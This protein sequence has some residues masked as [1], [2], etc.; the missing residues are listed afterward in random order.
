MMIEGLRRAK[1]A[2]PGKICRP[3]YRLLTS[4]AHMLGAKRRDLT[5]RIESRPPVIPG[6]VSQPRQTNGSA[7]FSLDQ[8]SR[9]AAPSTA[10]ASGL[11]GLDAVLALQGEPEQEER[12][13]RR[14]AARR[15][16]DLLDTLDSL[17]ISLLSGRVPIDQIGRLKQQMEAQGFPSGDPRLD[18]LIAHIELRA[19]VEL[20]K[21]A[22]AAAAPRD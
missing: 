20:A 3:V 14:Q 18:E 9:G 8:T 2:A 17:K 10:A 11:I 7:R 4:R 19:G 16:Y 15:G 6:A 1:P 22:A 21:I 5:M 13:R 12:R